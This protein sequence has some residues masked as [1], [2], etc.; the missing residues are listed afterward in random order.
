MQSRG[1]GDL[2]PE[3]D[4]EE[5]GLIELLELLQDEAFWSD[6]YLT[7]EELIIALRFYGIDLQI[8]TIH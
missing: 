5:P 7:P 2:K 8:E 6:E 4:F 1:A 3:S